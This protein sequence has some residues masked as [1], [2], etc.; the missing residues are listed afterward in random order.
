MLNPE[1]ANASS[2][3]NDLRS[4]IFAAQDLESE[5][6]E[7]PEWDVTLLIKTMNGAERANMMQSFADDQG[8]VKLADAVADIVIYTA[9][10][11]ATGVR[12]FTEDDRAMLNTKSGAAI[13][14]AAEVGMRLSGL[15]ADAIDR[16]GKD[17]SPTLSGD[18]S[19]N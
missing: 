15:T 12:V 3:Q 18:S 7:I 11:P 6:V 17:S 19:T 14:K 8:N 4:K 16:S 9:H 1:D 2:D 10:N 13:Q 5:L